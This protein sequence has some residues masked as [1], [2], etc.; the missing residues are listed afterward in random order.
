ML[1][2]ATEVWY[3]YA[4][5]TLLDVQTFTAVVTINPEGMSHT[6]PC[7][8]ALCCRNL[9]GAGSWYIQTANS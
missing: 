7:A 4:Q 6:M 8:H 2:H 1:L 9:P 5:H 3:M